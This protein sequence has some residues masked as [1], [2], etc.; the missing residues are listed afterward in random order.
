MSAETSA[1]AKEQICGDRTVKAVLRE[2]ANWARPD[3]AV[4]FLSIK[5]IA[6][7]VEVD[8][9][10]VKRCIARLEQPT[11][12]HP[13]RLGL[14]RRVARFREDGG[15]SASGFELVGY[16]PPMFATPG[17]IVS[18]PRDT[19]AT[20]PGDILS[21]E[22]V[23]PVSPLKRDK[24]ITPPC[25]PK[26]EQTPTPILDDVSG[27][28]AAPAG[29]G[30][31][32]QGARQPRGTR[33]PDDWTPP[34]Y[35]DLPPMARKSVELWPAGAYEA[36]C[37]TFRC[38]W[39]GETGARAFKRDWMA[40]L[41][42]WLMADHPKIMRDAKAGIS[43][44]HLAPIP[45]GGVRAAV[46]P[47]AAKAR[48]ND[49]SAAIHAAL[50]RDIGAQLHDQW[51]APAAVIHDGAG[52]SVIVAS[53]FQRAWLADR[54]QPKIEAAARAVIGSAVRWVKVIIESSPEEGE[55]KA[56]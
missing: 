31:A 35:A 10:T 2:I 54:F 48:E 12:D 6:A 15:Q 49:R 37:E 53:E 1:W 8:P 20:P 41:A 43:F 52:V 11:V 23:T 56:V 38:H 16:Q 9:R 27:E 33:L 26:G 42:K 39:Q 4:E 32:G 40:A 44:A 22:G 55:A 29:K 14:L 50:R 5:R 30:K 47:V 25:S 13:A 7:V 36:V 19:R 21:R 28:G 45:A 24:I 51:I 18:P 3:G 34:T 46:G 17:D